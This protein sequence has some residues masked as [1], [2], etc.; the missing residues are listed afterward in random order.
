MLP[1]VPYLT[2]PC[3]TLP[4]LTERAASS[5]HQSPDA[6]QT[7]RYRHLKGSPEDLFM[8]DVN[9]NGNVNAKGEI[10]T[11]VGIPSLPKLARLI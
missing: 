5:L 7:I 8:V 6:Q 1:Y 2:L 4:Y 3:L 11:G 10:G 9:L